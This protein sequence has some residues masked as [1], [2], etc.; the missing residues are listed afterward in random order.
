MSVWLRLRYLCNQ[1]VHCLYVLQSYSFCL[2][3]ILIIFISSF[4]SYVA[5]YPLRI[6]KTLVVLISEP[7]LPVAV[8]PTYFETY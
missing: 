2:L 6:C 3:I 7:P 1:Y 5:R 4:Q 8:Y